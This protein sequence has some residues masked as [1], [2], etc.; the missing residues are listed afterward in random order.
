M[1]CSSICRHSHICRTFAYFG[2]FYVN[3]KKK[4]VYL[5]LFLAVVLSVL[6][7]WV[8]TYCRKWR[9]LHYF[10]QIF[11]KENSCSSENCAYHKEARASPAY[12]S[13][14]L[15]V[16][17]LHVQW[18]LL[19]KVT[20]DYIRG[21]RPWLKGARRMDTYLQMSTNSNKSLKMSRTDGFT[22]P[23]CGELKNL[24]IWSFEPKL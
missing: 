8:V 23:D 15:F 14:H 7:I 16:S 17:G 12:R 19:C 10:L 2:W 13:F 1:A 11:P 3:E 21:K 5:C 20:F 9:T 6:S 4:K 18:S 24:L 22:E